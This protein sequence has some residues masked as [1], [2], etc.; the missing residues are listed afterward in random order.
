MSC[1]RKP[2]I[3]FTKEG[4]ID[5]LGGNESHLLGTAGDPFQRVSVV[6]LSWLRI[7]CIKYMEPL[8]FDS[9][10]K[11]DVVRRFPNSIHELII[12]GSGCVLYKLVGSYQYDGEVNHLFFFFFTSV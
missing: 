8:Y 10:A 12:L 5:H 6:V 3:K 11:T 7:M 2:F 1:R 4:V 9:L